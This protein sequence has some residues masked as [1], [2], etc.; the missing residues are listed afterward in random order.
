MGLYDDDNAS[1]TGGDVLDVI[2]W[3][4]KYGYQMLEAAL[5]SKQS[6]GEIRLL[7]ASVING[8]NDV[9]Q[10]YPNHADVKAW[11]AK[12][13]AIQAKV[14]P[15]SR[16]EGWR[17]DFTAW[18]EQAYEMGW[19]AANIARMAAAI[20]DWDKTLGFG[21]DAVTY[22]TRAKDRMAKWSPEAQKFVT[23]TLPE[24]EKLVAT[25]QGKS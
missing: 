11:L 20:Q 10:T 25:A 2:Y 18:G 3:Q 16:P 6:E 23:D 1:V 15:D 8:C 7:L 21:R 14:N 17:G 22:L 5:K 4:T 9:L 19:R 12:A 13:K 24:M